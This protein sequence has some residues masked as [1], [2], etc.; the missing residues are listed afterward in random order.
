MGGWAWG[1]GRGSMSGSTGRPRIGGPSSST[2]AASDAAWSVRDLLPRRW[3]RRGGGRMRHPR[4]GRGRLPGGLG[5]VGDAPL[6][7]LGLDVGGVGEAAEQGGL[8]VGAEDLL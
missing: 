7:Q 8:V 5:L 4:T 2:S 1:R 3:R 6:L